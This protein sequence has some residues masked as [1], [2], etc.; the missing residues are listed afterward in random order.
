MAMN[1]LKF[2]FSKRKLLIFVFVL[3]SFI[4]VFHIKYVKEYG[5]YTNTQI[6]Y[7]SNIINVENQRIKMASELDLLEFFNEDLIYCQKLLSDFRQDAT[8][9]TIAYDLYERDCMI[10]SY[11]NKG[12]KLSNF[13]SIL[14]DTESD[15][16]SC[17]KQEKMYLENQTYDFVYKN[18]PTGFYLL[19]QIFEDKNLFFYLILI[20]IVIINVDIWS[21][22]LENNT[23]RYVLTSGK[24]RSF[25]YI[26][27]TLFY[28]LFTMLICILFI[29]LLFEIGCV[30]YGS[31]S[32]LYIGLNSIV[33]YVYKKLLCFVFIGFFVCSIV[34]MMSLFTKNTGINLMISCL[35]MMFMYVYLD[36]NVLW[37]NIPIFIGLTIGIHVISFLKF[38]KSDL[39]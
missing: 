8:A 19:A 6:E 22:D 3:L 13:P 9:K 28:S 25:I 18:K 1:E 31:G 32:N 14:Q 30:F 36:S 37:Q 16:G 29:L 38:T 20:L 24:S 11:T 2:L 15:L 26:G 5:E 27:R 35:A 17:I 10:L 4:G 33:A 21:K 39:G 34:Q 23:L 7:Y 12:V